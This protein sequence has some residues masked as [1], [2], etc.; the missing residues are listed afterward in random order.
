MVRAAQ[1]AAGGDRSVEGQGNHVD[2][3]PAQLP[4]HP[5]IVGID[6]V[7]YASLLPIP[8]TT[9]RQP[10]QDIGK[11]AMATMFERL[12]NPELPIREISLNCR[13]VVRKS[14]GSSS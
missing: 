3:S 6:D 5:R 12:K 4:D 11:V 14:C 10:C 13:L 1:A 2:L 8:L 7:K 9:Q